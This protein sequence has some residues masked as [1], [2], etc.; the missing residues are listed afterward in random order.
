M[1]I[2]WYVTESIWCNEEL[3]YD[4]ISSMCKTKEIAERELQKS[5]EHIKAVKND[6]GY[7]E[8][9]SEYFYC[10]GADVRHLNLTYKKDKNLTY[11]WRIKGRILIES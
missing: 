9:I 4:S 3:M 2:I 10:D 7:G 1:I 8:C 5:I 11:N 6:L